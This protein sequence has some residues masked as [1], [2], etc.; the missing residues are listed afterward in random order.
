MAGNGKSGEHA[1]ELWPICASY[2]ATIN[3]PIFDSIFL[4]SRPDWED[5]IRPVRASFRGFLNKFDLASFKRIERVPA[6]CGLAENEDTPMKLGTLAS[7]ILGLTIAIALL[8]AAAWAAPCVA[9]PG[10]V[11][12]TS[13]SVPPSFV[14][15]PNGTA[16][17]IFNVTNNSPCLM[18][19]D[20]ALTVIYGPPDIDDNVFFNG[21]T[22]NTV[23]QPKQTLPMIYNVIN[24]F[25]DPITDCCDDGLNLI[26]FKIELS[27]ATPS[28]TNQFITVPA[29]YGTYIYPATSSSTGTFNPAIQAMLLACFN[30]PAPLPDPCPTTPTQLLFSN[31]VQGMPFPAYARVTVTDVPDPSTLILSGAGLVGLLGRFWRRRQAGP[32]PA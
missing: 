21:Q 15:N 16:N 14:E 4:D 32:P 29:P 30:N 13:M 7:S 19:L 2:R 27:P 17:V 22:F 5:N 24:T 18:V 23:W 10:S 1:P 8:D 6:I 11:Q 31:G 25:G 3:S 26:A 12:V 28:S 9:L 20:Y